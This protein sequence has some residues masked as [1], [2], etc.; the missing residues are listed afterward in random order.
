MLS[1]SRMLNFRKLAQ[2]E[3]CKNRGK[4]RPRCQAS[5]EDPYKNKILTF[6][7]I[8]IQKI[9]NLFVEKCQI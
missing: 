3:V 2:C 9:I 6:L 5:D 1:E 8:K 4:L 7:E